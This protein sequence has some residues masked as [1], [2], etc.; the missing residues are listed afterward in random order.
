MAT[1]QPNAGRGADQAKEQGVGRLANTSVVPNDVSAIPGVEK[2]ISG[3]A[4]EVARK[5]LTEHPATA[6]GDR[7]RARIV[8]PSNQGE[9]DEVTKNIGGEAGATV[10]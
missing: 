6:D 1:Q 7:D 3:P 8:P 9:S 2:P 5:D 4:Q 10:Y